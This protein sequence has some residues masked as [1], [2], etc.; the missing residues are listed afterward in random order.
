M[1]IHLLLLTTLLGVINE[2]IIIN[3]IGTLVARI[4]ISGLNGLLTNH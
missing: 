2:V 3:D 4:I 1:I